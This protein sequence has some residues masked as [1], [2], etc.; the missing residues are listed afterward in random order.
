M[1]CVVL[2]H[3][4]AACTT[5]VG[6]VFTAWRLGVEVSFQYLMFLPGHTAYSL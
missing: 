6:C 4:V 5:Y 1:C 2:G 3:G